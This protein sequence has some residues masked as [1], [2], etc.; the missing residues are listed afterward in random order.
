MA[1]I[2][3]SP[4]GYFTLQFFDPHGRRKTIRLGKSFKRKGAETVKDRVE[5]LVSAKASGHSWPLE[6]AMWESTIGD[7]L[8]DKLATAGLVP[9][10]E[11]HTL[12]GFLRA[13]LD[14]HAD[15]KPNTLKNYKA[16]VAK[17]LDF[18]PEKTDLRDITQ[19]QAQDW[20][21]SLVK[22]PR[23]KAAKR[24][25][26]DRKGKDDKPE[27]LSPKTRGRLGKFAR[28]F[29]NLGLKKKLIR[30]NP[31]LAVK[32]SEKRNKSRDRFITR[33]IAD[34]V[35]EAC[36]D[37]I[38]RLIFALTRFGGLRCPSEVLALQ[39]RDVN[40]EKGKM[41]VHASKTEHHEHGGERVIP[42]FAEIRPHLQ[43][44]HELA[45]DREVFVISRYQKQ[46]PKLGQIFGDILR[47]A[48]IKPWPKIFVNLRA[49][50]AT[51][52][53]AEGFP[54]HVVNEW[55]GHDQ[56]TAEDYY[57]QVTDADFEKACLGVPRAAK[58]AALNVQDG[59]AGSLDAKA[60]IPWKST[61]DDYGQ[62]VVQDGAGYL[63]DDVT[64]LVHPTGV[65]R[66]IENIAGGKGLRQNAD[67]SAAASM[68]DLLA[69]LRKHREKLT[70]A[71]LEN[72]RVTVALFAGQQPSK[73][74]L[75]HAHIAEL[76]SPSI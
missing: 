63:D 24:Q 62:E 27:P 41:L 4:Q 36:P 9:T 70:P 68:E 14:K 61:D 49:T 37:A 54:E 42:I 46:G 35:F 75:S 17:L 44:A 47:K 52:L 57:L 65:E 19:L 58:G 71:V 69:A 45:K 51:E 67:L 20:E 12:G 50:R 2:S 13:F 73:I 33:Q 34:Q 8:A 53:R 26:E 48:C 56:D 60:V 40:W 43:D 15:A 11:R 23:L 38:W 7:D 76:P 72:L 28:Q 39:W 29:F 16:A 64:G 10:R 30:E 25:G 22:K 6:L 31:F 32:A 1:S 21:A 5:E 18:F 74:E 3:K 55:M 66:E 59:A